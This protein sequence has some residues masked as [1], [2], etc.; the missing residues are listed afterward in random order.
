MFPH[1]K[2]KLVRSTPDTFKG[3]VLSQQSALCPPKAILAGI[4]YDFSF[5]ITSSLCRVKE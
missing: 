5:C 3:L 2:A 1:I 4:D